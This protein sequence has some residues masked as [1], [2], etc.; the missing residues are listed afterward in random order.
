MKSLYT[1]DVLARSTPWTRSW[2]PSLTREQPRL[3]ST[4]SIST[5]SPI[6]PEEWP[7]LRLVPVTTDRVSRLEN[8]PL[9]S[10]PHSP[11][12][13]PA[14]SS[15]EN[16]A[17]GSSNTQWSVPS[18]RATLCPSAFRQSEESKVVSSSL[19]SMGV[20][21]QSDGTSGEHVIHAKTVS[22]KMR[23]NGRGT[24]ARW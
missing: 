18:R 21:S 13:S 6:A 8:Y 17:G 22:P 7:I 23:R 5:P 2:P 24:A 15:S 16:L 14:V 10:P 19:G 9:T 4:G 20:W 12:F 11:S 3:T 1:H